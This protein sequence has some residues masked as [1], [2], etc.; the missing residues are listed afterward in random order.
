MQ[1]YLIRHA[2]SENNARPPEHREEDPPITDLGRTQAEYLAKWTGT[3]SIDTLITSPVRR[4][5][6]TTR[7]VR[8]ETDQHVHVWADVFEEGGIYR[9]YGPEA[10]HGG[11]GLSRSEVIR[12][13]ADDPRLCTLDASILDSGWWG[14]RD[15]E[16]PEEASV[17]ANA[18]TERL[19]RTF[20]ASGP[21]G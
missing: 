20:G 19:E 21:T 17:R 3:I 9:G 13:L 1:L 8:E 5:L 15:R 4:A 16:T 7:Y 14:G 12:H 10:T 2:E 18:V 11:L 6:Q